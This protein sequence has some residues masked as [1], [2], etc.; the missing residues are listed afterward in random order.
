MKLEDYIKDFSEEEINLLAKDLQRY[1]QGEPSA[2]LRM[3]ND[4]FPDGFFQI[5]DRIK[6]K[7]V[8]IQKCVN[9]LKKV[10]K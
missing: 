2:F 5:G 4:N 6:A 3:Q 1:A 9:E 10:K 8:S 7:S